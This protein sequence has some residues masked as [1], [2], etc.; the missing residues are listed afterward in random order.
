MVPGHPL[1]TA[2]RSRRTAVHQPAPLTKCPIRCTS[3]PHAL[4]VRVIVI[5]VLPWDVMLVVLRQPADLSA[6]PRPH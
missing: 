3:S 4:S 5:H 6:R 1:M 2:R